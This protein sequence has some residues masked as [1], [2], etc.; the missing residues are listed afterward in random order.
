MTCEYRFCIVLKTILTILSTALVGAQ[1]LRVDDILD[2]QLVL[3]HCN[4]RQTNK[5]E[6]YQYQALRMAFAVRNLPP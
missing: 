6:T 5:N 4:G 1:A 3:G 2:A